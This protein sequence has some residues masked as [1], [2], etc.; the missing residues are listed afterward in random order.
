MKNIYNGSN[1]YRDIVW[2]YEKEIEQRDKIP[3]NSEIY[4]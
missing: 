1:E 3:N 4:F 2:E